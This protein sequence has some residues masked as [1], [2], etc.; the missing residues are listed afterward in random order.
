MDG[1]PNIPGRTCCLVAQSC[2]TLCNPMDYSPPGWIKELLIW[3]S[4]G[5]KTVWCG[6][7]Q[8]ATK[9]SAPSRT[10]WSKGWS[11]L[12]SV[13]SWPWQLA[14]QKAGDNTAR[15]EQLQPA[16][17]EPTLCS[18]TCLHTPTNSS[19]VLCRKPDGLRYFGT[20]QSNPP[21]MANGRDPASELDGQPS[22]V[23]RTLVVL[24]LTPGV[25][26]HLSWKV[27]AINSTPGGREGD[28]RELGTLVKRNVGAVSARAPLEPNLNPPCPPATRS[29]SWEALLLGLS[30][31]PWRQVEAPG[32]P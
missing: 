26:E 22:R 30:L 6:R 31:L 24:W 12:S 21:C 20:Q 1:V 32:S 28:Y 3:G 8:A 7:P 15:E 2:P 11:G 10:M 23:P 25:A 13:G 14:P 27:G 5:Q 29:N 9:N 19:R 18:K 16:G 4:E 17:W